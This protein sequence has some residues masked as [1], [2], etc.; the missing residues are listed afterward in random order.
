MVFK[1]WHVCFTDTDVRLV[2][3]AENNLPFH[4][5]HSP[6]G[7][8]SSLAFILKVSTADAVQMSTSVSV[9]DGLRVSVTEFY[10]M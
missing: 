3:E 5:E 4:S 6:L 10:I 9:N 8:I 1:M 2:S 7:I